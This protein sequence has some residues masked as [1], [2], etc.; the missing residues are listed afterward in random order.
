MGFH[1]PAP[2]PDNSGHRKRLRERFLTG[3]GDALP[4]YE[5]LEL[6]LFGALPRKDTKGLAKAL[7]KKFGDFESVIAADPARLRDVPDVKDA[8]IAQI[9]VIEA[10]AQRLIPFPGDHVGLMRSGHQWKPVCPRIRSRS[11]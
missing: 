2:R 3:G 10:A 1:E 7:I 11:A 5:L 8:V 9:K 4:D 6:V